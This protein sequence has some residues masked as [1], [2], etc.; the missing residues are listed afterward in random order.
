ML[1]ELKAKYSE[2]RGM[3]L[4]GSRARG[5][6]VEDSNYDF[7]F[8][9]DKQI[10]Q[11]FKDSIRKITSRKMLEK[12]VIIDTLVY[13]MEDIKNPK[14]PIRERIQIEGIFYGI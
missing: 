3:Y 2:F 6:N 1:I 7:A 5:D 11:I 8:L 9:F 4:F 12:D 14:T 13:S 10:S